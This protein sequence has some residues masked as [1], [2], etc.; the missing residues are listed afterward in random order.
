V[1]VVG[2]CLSD[3]G[4]PPTARTVRRRQAAARPVHGRRPAAEDSGSTAGARGLR[5]PDGRSDQHGHTQADQGASAREDDRRPQQRQLRTPNP[6]AQPH[7][8]GDVRGP[9][10]DGVIVDVRNK[11]MMATIKSIE[12]LR[13][14]DNFCGDYLRRTAPASSSRDGGWSLIAPKARARGARPRHRR[15][16]ASDGPAERDHRRAG[17]P[18]RPQHR[19]VGRARAGLAAAGPPAR[20]SRRSFPT[21]TT[22][23]TNRV[24]AGAFAANGAS[25]RCVGYQRD[26]RVG[27]HRD[28]DHADQLAERRRRLRRDQCAG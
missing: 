16:S 13:G 7:V 9:G 12:A 20:A 24:V 11:Q 23:G 15:R 1:P 19:L 14:E 26:R 28:A 18:R 27:S 2:L 21:A 5:R 25:V 4:I 6:R 17:R 8:R 3:A 10:I 22:S